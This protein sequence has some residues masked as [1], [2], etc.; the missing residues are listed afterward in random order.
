[1]KQHLSFQVSCD[2]SILIFSLL[3][4]ALD[5]LG[6]NNSTEAASALLICYKLKEKSC[7]PQYWHCR[8][9]SFSEAALAKN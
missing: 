7:V 4:D 5:T 8:S 3:F 1:M 2:S 6:I 9:N